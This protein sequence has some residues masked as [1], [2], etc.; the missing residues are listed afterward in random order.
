MVKIGDS[1]A[2]LAVRD[3]G[4]S[5]LCVA[6]VVE[7]TDSYAIGEIVSSDDCFVPGISFDFSI[8][9]LKPTARGFRYAGQYRGGIR[10]P[11]AL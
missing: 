5:L 8:A 2:F 9:S 1:V 3:D 6:R 11:S 4:E 10:V 7:V